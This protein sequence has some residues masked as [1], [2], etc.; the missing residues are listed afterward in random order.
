M[1]FNWEHWNT[2]LILI[3]SL[4]AAGTTGFALIKTR[5]HLRETER[6]QQVLAAVSR[7]NNNFLLY[8]DPKRRFGELLETLKELTGSPIGFIGEHMETEGKPFM[9][10]Y[11][12][13]NLAW[14]QASSEL[15][16]T[17]IERGIDFNRLDNLFG[18]TLT[19]GEVIITNRR[20][21]ARRNRRVPEGHPD[22][23][24]FIGIPLKFQGEVLGMF[25]LANGQ[26]EYSEA[27]VEWLT[28]LTNTITGMMYAFRIERAQ[29]EASH[30]MLDAQNEAERANQIKSDFLATMSHEIRT[31]L[32]AVVGMLDTLSN[33]P[34]SFQQQDYIHT[35]ENAADTLLSL[36][37]DILDFSKIE[38][39]Q[40]SL[41]AQPVNLC[42]Q[43][44][45]VL[46]LA[47]VTPAARG[48]DLYMTLAPE[49][50]IEIVG[51]PVRLRQI[52]HNLVS[53]AVKFTHQGEISV[54][55]EPVPA[56]GDRPDGIQIVVEDT[57]IG[58][59]PEDLPII[60]KAF[61][62]VDHSTT[63]EYQGTGLGLAI[64][65]QLVTA[66]AGSI[67]VQSHPGQGSR[68]NVYLPLRSH[69]NE[70]LAS[71]LALLPLTSCRALCVT[72]SDHLYRYLYTLLAP[73]VATLDCHF[74]P[75][76][77]DEAAGQYDL[78]LIDD[79]RFPIDNDSLRYWVQQQ[80]GQGEVV[81]LSSRDL[82]ELFIPVSAQ[83]RVPLSPFELLQ[84][85]TGLY[86]PELLP[87]STESLS[88]PDPSG[89][90]LS[91]LT[92]G[93]NI[94]IAED[95]PVNQK[96]MEVLMQRAGADFQICDDGLEI[97]RAL[98]K[99]E[100]A[101]D[102]VLMDLHMPNMDG[103]DTTRAIRELPPPLNRI[104]IIAVTAD[105]LAGD[106]EKCLAAGMDDYLAKP[107]RLA[108]LQQ[109]VG[110]TLAANFL[111]VAKPSAAAEPKPAL[112]F[113]ADTLI[114]ELGAAENAV[115]LIHEF[116]STLH[117]ELGRVQQALDDSDLDRARSA[118][119]RV[120]GSARTL[121]CEQLAE[122]L[123]T[124]EH[125][126]RAEQLAQARAAYTQLEDA[127]PALELRLLNFCAQHLHS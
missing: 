10:C 82:E 68:F 118:A 99:A 42:Q 18:H 78:L 43:I 73:H 34:L 110:R 32:N 39:G 67:E 75:L 121:S 95:H 28:P 38:A 29:R 100:Q 61:R 44:H 56:Q 71:A 41:Q 92:Q 123:Q 108:D 50:P 101:F 114:A 51:D 98:K 116:A 55:V 8:K 102:L 97:L 23:H 40:L 65:H 49:T 126:C 16:D 33:T 76:I 91:E 70:T 66:M 90:S 36:V 15:Y 127:L 122:Q 58:I 3:S 57:G 19:T 83:V 86:R 21:Q 63:R 109:A 74:K 115:L 5:Q 62:Q 59:K 4:L 81:V 104:P 6:Q 12:I 30:R 79:Q 80:S 106:R 37:N 54:T 53:N 84:A 93:L 107:V 113:D 25:G 112:E 45:R 89:A 72:D 9:R 1:M 24:S 7:V 22:I 46:S 35:A 31:P 52:L 77:E 20:D 111:S 87:A 14:D 96:M 94:L 120:K 117:S 47:A 2:T 105:A 60:F 64:T 124:I 103:F 88:L 69:G 27:F 17:H 119:H 125:H 48:T 26:E 13:T 11:A 85:L